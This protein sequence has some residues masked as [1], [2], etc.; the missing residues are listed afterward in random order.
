M[1][2]HVGVPERWDIEVDL[3]AVGSSSGGL[4]AAITGHDL[5]LSTVL[6]EKADALGGGTALSGGALWVPYNH[7]M[8]EM[9]L[10]D[11]REEALAYIRSISV[12]RHDEAHLSTYLDT[13]PELIRHLE[14]VTPLKMMVDQT[15]GDYYVESPGG[16]STGRILIPDA[17]QVVPV[18]MEAEK[19]QPLIVQIRREPVPRFF[20]MREP[21]W[22]WGRTLIG[23]LVLGCLNRGIDI[24]TNTRAMQL[25]VENGR[26]IGL[27]A[28]R[29]GKDLFVKGRKGVVIATGGFEWNEEM[30][31]RY[32][33]SPPLHAIT[34]PSNEGDGHIMGIE[35]GAAVALMDHVIYNST[36]CIP[37]E[38]TEGRPYWRLF[39]YTIGHPGTIVVNRH[40]KRCCD[41]AFYFAVGQAFCAYDRARAEFSNVPLFWIGDQSYRDRFVVGPLRKGAEMAEWLQRADTLPEL[42]GQ[43]GLPA[44]ALVDTVERFNAFCREGHDPDFHRG[45]SYFDTRWGVNYFP[46]HSPPTLGPIEKP[47]FY[48]VQLHLGSV[49]NVGGL[50]TNTIG[51]V[52]DVRDRAIPGLYGTSNATALLCAGYGYQSGLSHTKSMIFGYLAARHMAQG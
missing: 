25:I 30:N 5:G 26:V 31:R 42:A 41:E 13:A 28:E 9:G 19:T 18:L 45:E 40:G 3:V 21:A 48:G 8:L 14:E 46:D 22:L 44:E 34:P 15:I 10:S 39:S 47:P 23:A 50:V 32:V 29:D 52:M 33:N 20:G 4:I 49:G 37:G 35:V 27:R 36:I 6:L 12:G 24:Y 17:E 7:H 2:E 11:S 16:K 43:L 51:Q 1:I 38:E